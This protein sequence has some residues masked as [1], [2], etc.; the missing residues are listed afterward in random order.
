VL[1][2]KQKKNLTVSMTAPYV[3]GIATLLEGG[4]YANQ[5]EIVKDALRRLFVHYE[6]K[7][8]T[9]EPTLG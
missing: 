6:I 2:Q 9:E 8:V 3:E 1:S 7:M 4:L 5:T